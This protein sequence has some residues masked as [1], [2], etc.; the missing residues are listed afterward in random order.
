VL[1]YHCC[2]R[3]RY[4]CVESSPTD[5]IDAVRGPSPANIRCA[6]DNEP[7][8][9]AGTGAQGTSTRGYSVLTLR[10]A[11][12]SERVCSVVHWNGPVGTESLPPYL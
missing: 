7:V 4:F 3:R 9:V 1:T 2:W 10:V 5:A 12:E 8:S 6:R 11:R